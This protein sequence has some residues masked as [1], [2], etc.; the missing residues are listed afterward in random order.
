MLLQSFTKLSRNFQRKLSLKKPF[1]KY[2]EKHANR[3]L[4]FLDFYLTK[5]VKICFRNLAKIFHE[6]L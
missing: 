6:R 1:M 5:N 3:F 2:Y 4:G